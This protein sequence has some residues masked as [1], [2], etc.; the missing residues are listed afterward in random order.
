MSHLKLVQITTVPESL[1]FLCGQ[2]GYM[3]RQ[4]FQVCAISSP[5]ER[6]TRFA[7][8]EQIE[9]FAV[10]MPRRITPLRDLVSLWKLRRLL[11]R[12]RPNIVHAHTPKGGLLGMLAAWLA[13]TPVRIY[14]M[15]GLPLMT[16]VGWKR[17]VLSWSER[18]ACALA[19]RVLCVSH[20]VRDAAV[21]LRLCSAEKIAVF[22]SG[23]I[24]GV[25]AE[26]RFNPR[27]AGVAQRSRTRAQLGIPEAALVL[28]FVGR[29]VRD[30]GVV[31]LVEA[32]HTL[33]AQFPQLHLLV[34]GPIEPQDPVPP[35]VVQQL[36]RDERIHLTGSVPDTLPYYTAMDVVALPTY[37]EGLPLVPL[38]AAAMML[39]VVATRV[40]GCV[41][42]VEDAVTGTLVPTRDSRTLADAVAAYLADG[43]LR[44]IHGAAARERV[45]R[46]FRPEAIWEATYHEYLR[47]LRLRNQ[48]VPHSE[49]QQLEPEESTVCVA[50]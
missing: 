32:W 2:I 36:H 19:H 40:P 49:S 45:L 25:D 10:P 42:A 20:S 35:H 23:S 13:R 11:R 9:A 43:A 38:E 17:T 1:S 22:G 46:D 3:R 30:K 27:A 21:D 44:R 28:G 14:H 47:L 26:R 4:G 5:G 6:L 50:R 34:V 24:N 31:E 33:R 16:A 39:P 37:R 8:Q 15:H 41:D 29:V 7:E 18:V 48:P 12:L